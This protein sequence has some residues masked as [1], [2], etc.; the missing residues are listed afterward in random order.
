M[1]ASILGLVGGGTFKPQE[2]CHGGDSLQSG[3][4]DA[5]HSMAQGV[6]GKVGGGNAA[7]H[8]PGEQ[9]EAIMNILSSLGHSAE[10]HSPE[11]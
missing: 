3:M 11:V 4:A 10:S 2:S 8:K 5:F 9:M 1:S 7:D 6:L